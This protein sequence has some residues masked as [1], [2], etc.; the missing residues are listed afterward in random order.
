MIRFG[1]S[2]KSREHPF[3]RMVVLSDPEANGGWVV[4]VRVTTDDGTWPDTACIIGPSDW[5]ELKHGST[6]AYSTAKTGQ[7]AAA[8]TA[9][10]QRGLFEVISSPPAS[11][12]QKMIQIGMG[13]RETPPLAKKWMVQGD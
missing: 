4:L 11:I 13:C 9:A 7:S 3:H 6:V 1:T 8:L 2:V 12:L 5:Q 10:I